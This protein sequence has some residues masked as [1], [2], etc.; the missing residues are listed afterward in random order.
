MGKLI[1]IVGGCY[2][3]AGNI[4]ELYRRTLA[5]LQEFPEY[6]YEFVLADNCSTDGTRDELRSLATADK[7]FR[8][9]FNSRNFGHIRSPFNAVIQ[10]RGDAVV[11]MCTDLQ[12]PPEVIRDFIRKWQE[13]YKV[14]IGVRQGTRANRLVEF[15]RR[16]Y[17]TLLALTADGEVI[18]RFTGFGLY[19]RCFME[20]MRKY[21][22]PYPYLR[23]LVS[24]IG[25]R[26]AEIGYIQ[27]RRKHGKT[28]NN[29]FTLYDIA[30]TGFVNHTKLPLRL[31]VFVGMCLGALSFLSAM[32]Y[33]VYK[34]LYWNSFQVGMAPLVIG[35]F[36][37]SSVQLFFIGILGEYLGAVWTQVKNRPLAIEEER[38]N[39]D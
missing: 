33:L 5:V 9:I 10:A 35:L 25:F 17:Y 1:S 34:L 20:A 18:P 11:V 32:I 2:N 30:M 12:D 24:E 8:V 7:K 26:R 3:E 31:A 13:G 27:E 28:K 37:F 22:D 23:G 4:S 16:C 21:H 19:D 38:I 39:F 14:V 15:G 29:Y 36:F 6:D